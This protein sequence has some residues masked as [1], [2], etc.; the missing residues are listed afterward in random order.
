MKTYN[1]HGAHYWCFLLSYKLPSSRLPLAEKLKVRKWLEF[2][3]HIEMLQ[4]VQ[5]KDRWISGVLDLSLSPSILPKFNTQ[6]NCYLTRKWQRSN[7]LRG[8]G[9]ENPVKHETHSPSPLFALLRRLSVV[10]KNCV[11]LS[12]SVRTVTWGGWLNCQQSSGETI[13]AGE[14][15]FT[16]LVTIVTSK[17]VIQNYYLQSKINRLSLITYQMNYKQETKKFVIFLVK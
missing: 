6:V 5:E 15:G 16:Y 1:V 7:T 8:L 3:L 11:C 17:R 4:N 12:V 2:C 9:T 10:I 13:V 14:G